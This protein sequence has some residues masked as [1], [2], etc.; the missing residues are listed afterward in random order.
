MIRFF[1]LQNGKSV[2]LP[3]SL[4][5]RHNYSFSSHFFSLSFAFS[6][7][8][9]LFLSFLAGFSVSSDF[10]SFLFS[11]VLFFIMF[12]LPAYTVYRTAAYCP[13]LQTDTE[14]TGTQQFP[15][16]LFSA[17]SRL[18]VFSMRP[19]LLIHT[20]STGRNQIGNSVRSLRRLILIHTPHTGRNTHQYM[21]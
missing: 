13:F 16:M 7:F 6:F 14:K 21:E 5:F 15:L 2:F 4:F 1:F 19:P 11:L 3:F 10:F 8:L 17:R 20:P 18:C 12:F 9:F